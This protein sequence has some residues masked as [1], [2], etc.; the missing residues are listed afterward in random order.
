[1]NNLSFISNNVK[2]LQAISKRGKVFE[3]LKKYVTSNGFIVLQETHSSVKD[4]KM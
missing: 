2:A 1:M 3:Y 4:E